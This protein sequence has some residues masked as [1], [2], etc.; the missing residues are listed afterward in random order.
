MIVKL[1]QR[2]R[3]IYVNLENIAY[4]YEHKSEIFSGI[5]SGNA[6]REIIEIQFNS[7]NRLEVELSQENKINLAMIHLM[8]K[9]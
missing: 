7:G 4:F 8:E 2:D 3:Y 1:K 6:S 9:K 5:A